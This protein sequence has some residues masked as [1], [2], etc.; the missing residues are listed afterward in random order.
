M[1]NFKLLRLGI[2]VYISFIATKQFLKILK[3]TLKNKDGYLLN[4]TFYNNHERK[5]FISVSREINI[6]ENILLSLKTTE[7]NSV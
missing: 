6:L 4:Y 7:Y 5:H 1:I 2:W 3:C